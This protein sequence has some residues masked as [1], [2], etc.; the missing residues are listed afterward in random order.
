MAHLRRHTN[1]HLLKSPSGHLVKNVICPGEEPP[2]NTCNDCDPPLPDTLYLTFAGL[3]G[4]FAPFNGKWTL[5]WST[6]CRW[7]AQEGV[8]YYVGLVYTEGVWKASCGVSGDC[9][10]FCF[11]NFAQTDPGTSRQCDPW[12]AT[13]AIIYCRP[14]TCEDSQSCTDSAGATCV[15][16]LT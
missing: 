2:E 8:L 9:V 12:N 3:A 13:Y 11:I 1:G 16:S 14:D 6:A 10:P 15:V 7:Y 5:V 4:D